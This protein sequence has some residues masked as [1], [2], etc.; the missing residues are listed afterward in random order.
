M[1][2]EDAF[3]VEGV[4]VEVLS[5]RTCHVKLT[6][7]HIVFGFLTGAARN[8]VDL[9]DGMKLLIKLSPFDL[10]EGRVLGEIKN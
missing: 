1:P 4:V 8:Q 2:G 7:G 9:M 10:S 6:N 3:T 5:E